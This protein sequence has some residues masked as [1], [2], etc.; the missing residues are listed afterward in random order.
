MKAKILTTAMSFT[1]LNIASCAEVNHEDVS[2][3]ETCDCKKYILVIEAQGGC[4]YTGKYSNITEFVK[5]NSGSQTKEIFFTNCDIQTI[6]ESI[7][8]KDLDF[9]LS[10]YGNT[11]SFPPIL[12]MNSSDGAELEP[13][14]GL[15]AYQIIMNVYEYKSSEEISVFYSQLSDQAKGKIFVSSTSSN[16][17]NNQIETFGTGREWNHSYDFIDTRLLFM[18]YNY[19]K[20]KLVSSKE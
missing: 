10:M 1:L 16:N 7:T 13:T 6:A 15:A 17:T 19:L 18:S 3:S 8:L 5:N 9:L 4:G 14:V 11:N 2:T 20:N 12:N